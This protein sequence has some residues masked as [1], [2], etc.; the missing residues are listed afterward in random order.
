MRSA[1]IRTACAGLA[2]LAWTGVVCAQIQKGDG[3]LSSSFAS[4]S[5]VCK[6]MPGPPSPMCSPLMT[7]YVFLRDEAFHLR[8]SARKSKK[9]DKEIAMKESE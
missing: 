6:G 7:Q 2:L 4:S 9:W 3:G 8:E 1:I 5:S